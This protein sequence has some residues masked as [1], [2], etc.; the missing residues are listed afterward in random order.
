MVLFVNVKPSVVK[1]STFAQLQSKLP[2]GSTYGSDGNYS[3]YWGS[4]YGNN[5]E[6]A[7]VYNVRKEN[8]K[9]KQI[10]YVRGEKKNRTK[11]SEIIRRKQWIANVYK[12]DLNLLR[13]AGL[14][15]IQEGR[16]FKIVKRN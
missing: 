12:F 6:F 11:K 3:S 10:K 2:S 5:K 8:K 7:Y 4:F 13:A 9:T 15:V 16:T 14:K 1:A